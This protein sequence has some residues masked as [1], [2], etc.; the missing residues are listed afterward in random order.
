[1]T[2]AKTQQHDTSKALPI[3]DRNPNTTK[4]K[5][6]KK[7]QHLKHTRQLQKQ[8]LFAPQQQP[9]SNDRSR[10]PL[11]AKKKPTSPQQAI[12]RTLTPFVKHA[13]WTC[14]FP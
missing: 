8:K 5:P 12:P 11:I 4:H 3:T 9:T 1:M 14:T 7:Q 6:P 2:K 13:G 10:L